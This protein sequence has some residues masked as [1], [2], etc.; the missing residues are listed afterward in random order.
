LLHHYGSQVFPVWL[1]IVLTVA[2]LAAA[3]AASI[4]WQLDVVGLAVGPVL[5]YCWVGL[6]NAAGHGA[7][8]V[9]E[10]L[11]IVALALVITGVAVRRRVA[12]R[13]I[14][15]DADAAAHAASR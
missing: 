6:A 14:D 8:A 7:P 9:V 2:L 1:T 3:V 15:S 5:T 11:L 4:R 13:P 12:V 10:Q